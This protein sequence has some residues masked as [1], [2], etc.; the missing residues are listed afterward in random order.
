MQ[1]LHPWKWFLHLHQL[2]LRECW[3]AAG[4]VAGGLG[5]R[6][7]RGFLLGSL[8]AQLRT[9]ALQI[10]RNNWVK[11]CHITDSKILEENTGYKGRL[12][13][14]ED[15]ALSISRVTMQDARTFVCQVGAGSHGTGENRTELHVYSE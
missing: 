5:C 10:D 9:P 3:P 8:S 15:K 12:S 6:L 14:G 4:A 2:V 7:A 13:V 11:L 1:L